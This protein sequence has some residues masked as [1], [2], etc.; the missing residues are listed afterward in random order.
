M[1]KILPIIFGL[2]SLHFAVSQTVQVETKI[3]L[4]GPFTAG[5]MTTDLNSSGFLPLTQPYGSPPWNYG[6][7][8]TVSAIPNADIVDWVLIDLVSVTFAVDTAKLY[9]LD[10]KA[11]FLLKTGLVKDFDG[12]SLPTFQHDGQT[13][14]HVRVHHRNHMNIISSSELTEDLGLYS[15]DFSTG[16]EKALGG[17]HTQKELSP[18]IW[19]MIS[20]DGNASG[21]VNNVDKNEVWLPELGLSG[22]LFG[23]FNMNGQVDMDDKLTQ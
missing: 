12:V 9:L 10:R 6:G 19:G 22:Y 3:F 11:C 21:Q 20:S 14:F 18:G 15:W 7:V 13:P 16:S 5:Q 4:E 2:V 8:E 17:V 1:K 23:D